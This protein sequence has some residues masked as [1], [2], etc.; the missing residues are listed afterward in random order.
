MWQPTV[1]ASTIK[2]KLVLMC[3]WSF[4]LNINAALVLNNH[5]QTLTLNLVGNGEIDS[6]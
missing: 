1:A 6:Q 2:D 3:T 4:W 5:S